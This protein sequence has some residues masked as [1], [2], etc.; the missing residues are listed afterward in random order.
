[1][2]RPV[3]GRPAPGQKSASKLLNWYNA[4]ILT[5]CPG[6]LALE[7]GQ[8]VAFVS[9][10]AMV[11]LEGDPAAGVNVRVIV[12]VSRPTPAFLMTVVMPPMVTW[13]EFGDAQPF[14]C[15]LA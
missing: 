13:Q 11:A 10:L 3:T 12:Y 8:I 4:E 6:V 5:I 9:W 14:P 2:P 7:G 15:M 1:M